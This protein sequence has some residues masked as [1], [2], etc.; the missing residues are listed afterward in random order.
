MV[1][2]GIQTKVHLLKK[3]ELNATKEHYFKSKTLESFKAAISSNSPMV[4][5]NTNGIIIE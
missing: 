2:N 5:F 1:P 3:D 4:I